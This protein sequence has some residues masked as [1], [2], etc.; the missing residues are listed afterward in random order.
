MADIIDTEQA[1]AEALAA[2]V[3]EDGGLS[4]NDRLDARVEEI[5]SGNKPEV[6]AA[7]DEGTTYADSFTHINPLDLPPELQAQYKNMQ[8][9]FT[10]AQQ[11]IAE[12]RKQYEALTEYGGLDV[13]LEAVQ[14]AQ[15][16][17]S[18]P[19]FAM[20]VQEQ[21]FTA[22]TDAGMSPKAAAA[23][24]QRQVEEA[25]NDPFEDFED[26][27]PLVKE[28]RAVKEQLTEVTNWKTQQDMEAQ[29]RQLAAKIQLQENEILAKNPDYVQDDIDSIYELAYS[30][31]GDLVAAEKRYAATQQRILDGYLSR[32]AS[33]SA[34]ASGITSNGVTHAI[35]AVEFTGLYDPKLEA[36]VQERLAQE[37]AAGN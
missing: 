2:A 10:K 33:V 26:D 31:G 8:G 17:A 25:T 36:L 30:T 1:A 15:N 5:K 29:N 11:R 20:Q 24:V 13:A 6:A 37:I 7:D 21:L 9:E 28:L 4:D 19:E 34:G 27:D 16:L 35:E 23:E 12:E 22:L 32:K 14:F 18:D 3:R